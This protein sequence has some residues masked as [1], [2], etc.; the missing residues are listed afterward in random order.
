MT[1]TTVS[2][3]VEWELEEA[4]FEDKT[5]CSQKVWC[6][7]DESNQPGTN[8]DTQNP[9]SPYKTV[10]Y[11]VK[12]PI[13]YSATL[14]VRTLIEISMG[15]TPTQNLNHTSLQKITNSTVAFHS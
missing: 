1:V 4:K 11:G 13:S 7:S 14:R 6:S 15:K 2:T 10:I 9:R 3:W 12:Q 5:W 8:L